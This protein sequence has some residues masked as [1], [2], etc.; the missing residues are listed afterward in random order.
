MKR[1][2]RRSIILFL[3][4]FVALA[5]FGCSAGQTPAP[6]AEEPEPTPV[7]KEVAV[8]YLKDS[9]TDFYLVREVHKLTVEPDADL[10]VKALEELITG[11][12]QTESAF[13]VLPPETKI[14]SVKVENGLATVDFSPDVLNANVG[15]AGEA[16]GIASIVNTLCEFDDV[17]KVSFTVNGTVDERTKDWWGHVGLYEQPFE[18]NMSVVWEPTIWVTEPKEGDLVTSPIKVKGSARVFEAAVSLRLVDAN[19]NVLNKTFTMASEGAPGRG[20]FEA[21]LTFEQPKTDTGYVE[22]FWGSPKD[23]SEMDLVR[24]PVKF[25]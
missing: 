4:L 9:G 18:P 11:T 3:A 24:I 13:K 16:L 19:G 20:T 6:P 14:L 22:V 25:K 10:K 5:V 17:Q 8:Y 2:F 12:P 15:A 21:E 7:E 1:T 23:G